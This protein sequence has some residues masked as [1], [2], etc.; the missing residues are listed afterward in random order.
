MLAYNLGYGTMKGA[1]SCEPLIGNYSQRILVAGTAWL[2]LD[3]LWC[4]IRHRPN[5][6]LDTLVAGTLHKQSN[7]KVAE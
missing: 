1:V 6:L 4:H 7:T 2:S 5:D 3:L